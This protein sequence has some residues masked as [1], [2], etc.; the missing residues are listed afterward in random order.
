[1]I[2]NRNG[3]VAYMGPPTLV[4]SLSLFLEVAV[5]VVLVVLFV[6]FILLSLLSFI[7]I[8]SLLSLLP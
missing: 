6:S 3:G 8:L 1:M 2:K 4:I 7:S 5:M